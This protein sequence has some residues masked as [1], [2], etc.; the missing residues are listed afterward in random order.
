MPLIDVDG[1]ALHYRLDGPADAPVVMLANSLGTTLGLWESQMADL[2]RHFR[3][4]R[5]DMRGQGGSPMTHA[6]FDVARLAEDALA[7][8]DVLALPRVH[9]CGLSLGG[10]VGQWLGA[11]APQR[12]GKLALCNT[13]ATLGPRSSWDARIEAVERGGMSAIAG[14]VL[15][16]WF[17]P[18]F[19]RRDAGAVER[20]RRMLLAATPEY[21]ALACGAARDA[22]QRNGAAEVRAPTLV[23]AGTHDRATPPSEGRWLAQQIAGARYVELDAAHLSNIEAAAA[24]NACLLEFLT[25]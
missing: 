19:R 13:A 14:M 7:L 11:R 16:R 23:V 8:I 3:V 21:Y 24:F 20:V 25:T 5:Y 9:F 4:L 2:L 12:L 10:V 15:E 22:D 17:T 6:P 1:A 18:E